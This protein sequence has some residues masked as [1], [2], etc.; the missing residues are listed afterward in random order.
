MKNKWQYGNSLAIQWL[1]LYTSTAS[2]RFLVGELRSHMLRGAVK[3]KQKQTNQKQMAINVSPM[4]PK[5]R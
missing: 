5:P 1:G 4:C 2:A 3:T